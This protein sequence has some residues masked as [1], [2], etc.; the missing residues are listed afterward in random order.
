M[1]LSLSKSSIDFR[2]E[3]WSALAVASGN[4]FGTPEW[5]S[6]WWRHFGGRRELLMYACRRPDGT[7]AGVL[8]I[9]CW[10]NR[11]LRI[12]RVLGHGPGD[13]NGPVCHRDDRALL[14]SALLQALEMED[15]AILVGEGLPADEGWDSLGGA[16]LIRREPSPVLSL[17]GLS[18]ESFLASRSKS[19]RYELGRKERRLSRG[20]QVHWRLASGSAGFERDFEVLLGLH[21]ARWPEGSSFSRAERFHREFA[22]LAAEKGWCRLWL[23]EIDGHARAA[24]YG[25]RFAN[26]ELYYQAGRDPAWD[27]PRSAISF[28]CTPFGKRRRM[29]SASITSS[30]GGRRSSI[31]SPPTIRGSTPLH[32]PVAPRDE[33]W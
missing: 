1:K 2:N 3:E 6:T 27:G 4:I 12:V 20:H 15:A 28:S 26:T 21:R 23:L 9:Y 22:G 30:V 10:L 13:R 17:A 5:L 16:R 32:W 19:F 25:F 8:P 7:L 33:L 29:A 18:W 14:A 31:D 24:W 11:P